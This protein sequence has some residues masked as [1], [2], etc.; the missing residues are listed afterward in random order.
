MKIREALIRLMETEAPAG[1]GRCN[2]EN[3]NCDHGEAPCKS[4]AGKRKAM[5]VGALCD[6]CA[7]KMPSKYMQ[8]ADSE[9][10]TKPLGANPLE[11]KASTVG[12][13]ST[14]PLGNTSVIARPQMAA[15]AEAEKG[16]T[17]PAYQKPKQ[18]GKPP[19][20]SKNRKA[21]D[22]TQDFLKQHGMD[23]RGQKV[24]PSKVSGGP[25]GE[26]GPGY[27]GKFVGQVWDTSKVVSKNVSW[28]DKETGDPRYGKVQGKGVHRMVWDGQAWVTDD[29]FT[30]KFGKKAEESVREAIVRIMESDES[31]DIEDLGTA[32]EMIDA[33]ELAL[34]GLRHLVGDVEDHEEEE[35]DVDEAHLGFKKLK[36]KLAHQKGVTDPAALAASIGRKKYGTAGMA[37]KSAAGRKKHESMVDSYAQ[38][39][40]NFPWHKFDPDRQS[41]GTLNPRPTDTNHSTDDSLGFGGGSSAGG[42]K[43]DWEDIRSRLPSAAANFERAFGPDAVKRFDFSYGGKGVIAA[44]KKNP[45]MKYTWDVSDRSKGWQQLDPKEAPPGFGESRELGEDHVYRDSQEFAE[46]NPKIDPRVAEK[47]LKKHGMEMRDYLLDNPQEKNAQLIDTQNLLGWMGY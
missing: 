22:M 34:R 8:E 33:I 14:A 36:G 25:G 30:K 31:E 3:L 4:P 10:E 15:G 20:P 44:S 27:P 5:Y 37:K 32:E 7:S 2:C 47:I 39:E 43:V 13:T 17:M 29:E 12:K 19:P 6:R 9:D 40:A 35:H 38:D 42:K 1:A 18:V 28:K 26:T 16:L 45:D 46:D 21:W 11:P 23:L 41:R 24:A